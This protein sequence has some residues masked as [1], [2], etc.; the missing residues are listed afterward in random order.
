VFG[1]L[2]P[3]FIT[4]CRTHDPEWSRLVS[5]IFRQ[6]LRYAIRLLA[7]DAGFTAI[8]LAILALT[9]GA[10]VT[11]FGVVDGTLLRPLPFPDGNRIVALWEVNRVTHLDHF[12]VS[13]PNFLDWRQQSREVFDAIAAFD[14]HE[15]NLSGAPR[16]RKSSLA[17][18]AGSGSSTS[19]RFACGAM[20]SRST[21]H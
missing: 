6:D 13:G 1:H 17:S 2:K 7:K 12:P 19:K 3:T 14:T 9:I 20:A 16:K 4:D 8:V 21:S 10:T 5:A 11:M 18:L 15:A